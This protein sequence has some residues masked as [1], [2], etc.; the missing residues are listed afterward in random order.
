MTITSGMTLGQLSR[1]PKIVVPAA[2]D[3]KI[4]N[5]PRAPACT[6]DVGIEEPRYNL[7]TSLV[8][9]SAYGRNSW[10]IEV[11]VRGKIPCYSWRID[12]ASGLFEVHS[13]LLRYTDEVEKSM[14]RLLMAKAAAKATTEQES[15]TTEDN[16]HRSDLLDEFVEEGHLLSPHVAARIKQVAARA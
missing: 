15:E 7:T 12:L 6:V 16:A 4:P 13:P 5:A 8:A 11:H 1:M 10:V 9:V 2:H 14:V 3:I